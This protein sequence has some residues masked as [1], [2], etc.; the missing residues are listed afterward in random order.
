MPASAKHA[1]AGFN[2]VWTPDETLKE[3]EKRR[4]LKA[5]GIRDTVK[6]AAYKQQNFKIQ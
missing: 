2:D 1:L 6:E 5:K 4:Y 3:V